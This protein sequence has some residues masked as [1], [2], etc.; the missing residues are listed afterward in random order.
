MLKDG[1]VTSVND[2]GGLYCVPAFSGLLA[3]YWN[4]DAKGIYNAKE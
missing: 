3:P 4:P 2:N 1:L